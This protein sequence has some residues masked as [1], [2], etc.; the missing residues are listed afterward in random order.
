MVVNYNFMA[1]VVNKYADFYLEVSKNV[2]GGDPVV[3]TY[4]I[5]DEHSAIGSILNPSTGVAVMYNA[6]YTGINAKEMG[7]E[8]ATT[9]YAIDANGKGH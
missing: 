3:T 1:A 2:A 8:F 5:T 4:G 7:D 9:L 6:A